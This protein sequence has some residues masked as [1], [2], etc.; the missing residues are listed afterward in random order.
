MAC[1][2]DVVL[3]MPMVGTAAADMESAR[4]ERRAA[5]RGANIVFGWIN[6]IV[7]VVVVKD[8]VESTNLTVKDRRECDEGRRKS[9]YWRRRRLKTVE[10]L[11]T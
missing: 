11:Y 9:V 2:N 6:C 7:V 8:V 4:A 10:C 1:A 3:G 5:T